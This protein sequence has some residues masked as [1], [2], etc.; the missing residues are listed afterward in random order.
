MNSLQ[1][2]LNTAIGIYSLI[3]MLRMWM[4][5]SRAD[6]YHPISQAVVKWTDPALNPLRKTFKARKGIDIAALVFVFVL[7]MVKLPL[8][9]ILGGDWTMD[10]ITN[11]LLALLL[12]GVLSIVRAFGEMILYVIFI[13]AI[14]SWFRRGNDPLSYLLYQLG[15]PVLSPIRRLLPKTGMIDFS[16]MVLAFILFWLNRVLWDLAPTIWQWA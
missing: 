6:F 13:G 3:V 16:P 14:L 15:E 4:Q 8:L 1:Y 2:L 5:Y 7:G 10:F 11:N 12:L 9:L